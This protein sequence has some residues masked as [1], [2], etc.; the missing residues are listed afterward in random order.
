L[1]SENVC[2][3]AYPSLNPYHSHSFQNVLKKVNAFAVAYNNAID[4]I[5]ANTLPATYLCLSEVNATNILKT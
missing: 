1:A 3:L 4:P 2:C 5:A